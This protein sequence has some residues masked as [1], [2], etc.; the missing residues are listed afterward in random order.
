MVCARRGRC[1]RQGLCRIKGKGGED[2]RVRQLEADGA[3]QAGSQAGTASVALSVS[4]DT[5]I[6]QV[7]A[8]GG[9]PQVQALA[10]NVEEEQWVMALRCI[11]DGAV[12]AVGLD[13]VAADVD[14]LET[15][16]WILLGSGSDEHC[17]PVKWCTDRGQSN[18]SKPQYL[19]DAQ[20][21]MVAM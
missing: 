1:W 14:S 21:G 4:P 8:R 9:A 17:C 3:S 20:G 19:R 13:G 11:S 6:S 7:F 12:A 18:N 16:A 5:S 15:V 2:N 10:T